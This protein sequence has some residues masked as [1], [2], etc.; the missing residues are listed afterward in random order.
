[1]C[2]K[3]IAKTLRLCC[4]SSFLLTQPL[5][6]QTASETQ[7]ITAEFI[8][9][10]VDHQSGMPCFNVVRLKN[11]SSEA[12]FLHPVL[13]LSEN[14]S[15]IGEPPGDQLIAAGDSLYLPLR[16]KSASG[17][18][19]QE[20]YDVFFQCYSAKN[21]LLATAY[22]EIVTEKTHAWE[23]SVSEKRVLLV[24][25]LNRAEFSILV[26]N[27]GNTAETISL[28]VE[29][30]LKLGIE[31]MSTDGLKL[32][33]SLPPGHDTLLR[34][35]VTY[36]YSEQ[37]IFD[38]GK[39]QIYATN[40][41]SKVYRSV[42]V[43]KYSDAY[44]PFVIEQGLLH[45]TEVGVRTFSRNN[46]VLPFIKTRGLTTMKNEGNFS[47]NFT[48]Y[49]LT[50]REDVIGN[51]YYQFLYSLKSLK[52]GLGAFS[53]MLGRNLYSRN[54]VMIADEIQLSP[55]S[56]L[57]GYTSY[58]FIDHKA[59]VAMGYHY[60]RGKR[61]MKASGSYDDDDK[62]KTKTTSFV[63]HTNKISLSKNHDIS[64]VIY[65]YN[66]KHSLFSPYTLSGLAYD[67]NYAA[68]L[69]DKI[70][71]QLM[72]N[73]GTA[74]IPGPQMGLFNLMLRT[75]FNIAGTKNY[76][77]WTLFNT[78]RNYHQYNR[79][80]IKSPY[81]Y[82]R[83][84]FG[85]VF[86]HFGN[87]K[88]LRFD[89][90]PSIEFYY[91]SNPSREGNAR[92]TFRIEKYRVEFKAFY[93]Q[94]LMLNIKYGLG[95]LYYINS[96]KPARSDY[97]LH[98]LTDVNA[99]GY[100]MQVRY[101]YGP[102][103]NSG[104]YQYAID[105][106][107]NGISIS[108][109]VLK[110]FLDERIRLTLFSNL[111]YRFDLKYGTINI[112]PRVEAY[113]YRNWYAVMSGSYNYTRQHFD[114]GNFGNSF[115]YLEFA[116]KKNWGKSDDN[117]WK[118]DLRRLNIQMFKDE[119]GNGFKD[120]NEVGVPNIKV[121]LRLTN[122]AKQHK[123]GKLPVDITLVTN[124]K[125]I[126]SFNKIPKG[127]YEM[128]ITALDNLMEYFY[129][130]QQ[131]E[132]IEVL[133][134]EVMQVPFQ[135]AN[136]LGGRI[137]VK[138]QKFIKDSELTVDM[139]NIKVTAYNALGNSYAAFTDAEGKFNVYVP[140]NQ[141]Y[142]VRIANVFGDHFVILNNDINVPMPEST[143]KAVV[144]Q[145]VERNRQINFKKVS[146]PEP[147]SGEYVI[148]KIKVLAGR[149]NQTE[150]AGTQEQA[151][152][153]KMNKTML[154]PGMFYVVLAEAKSLAEAVRFRQLFSEQGLVISFGYDEVSNVTY[155]YTNYYAKREEAQKEIRIIEKMGVK[156]VWLV[157]PK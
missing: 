149:M 11:H 28:E 75:R 23:V 115:Y 142:Y 151:F 57:E 85:S 99:R 104:L 10:V 21:Q 68:R 94:F 121:R 107:T 118:N 54:S 155:V 77:A 79:E 73:M 137:E 117:Q 58:G 18:I 100:G 25:N 98:I 27:T 14:W 1:V 122:S 150:G 152:K 84:Q 72:N 65:A 127:F 97:D 13:K 134:N 4:F 50:D 76:F 41:L 30:D 61:D 143:G 93:K 116:V 39:V 157:I 67:L 123:E 46:E 154:Q 90:G 69:T 12:V 22:F 147:D 91:A 15:V 88:S 92:E 113:V 16:F 96:N 6:A 126:V 74:E 45:T 17:A 71:I 59:S 66:E 130:G 5:Y 20:S 108:P 119:N 156:R 80:G 103:A 131:V 95:N 19:L 32:D 51:S 135:K 114:N 48:Y 35:G 146:K 3:W 106:K 24:P 9:P 133:K 86:F 8:K 132:K 40:G 112:N 7:A 139:A 87:S 102:M 110:T 136:K 111:V 36:N 83:D 81:L 47:Y 138:R 145:V 148:Q 31:P 52:A 33:L 2:G 42:L 34:F 124:E 89:A 128:N 140:G 38:V 55:A 82:L 153:P 125:G 62:T 37:R 109:F 26:S 56:A 144:F 43:E 101:D 64:A 129:V 120:R 29:P 53:S 60:T 105:N 70:D 44:S 78:E 141:V 49:N 63:L